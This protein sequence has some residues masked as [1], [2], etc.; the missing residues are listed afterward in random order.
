[1]EDKTIYELLRT[2]A[3]TSG[4]IPAL[5]NQEKRISY[6]VLYQ[7]VLSIAVGLQQLGYRD[8][9]VELTPVLNEDFI[10]AYLAL[11]VAGAVVVIH[12]EGLDI[13]DYEVSVFASVDPA[14]IVEIQSSSAEAYKKVP[15]D[16]ACTL[17]FTSGTSGRQKGVLLTQKN[18]VSDAIHGLQAVGGTAVLKPGDGTIP[19]LP[20]FHMFGITA[21][22]VASLYANLTLHLID[23][24]RYLSRE[25]V[26]ARPKI[27]FLVPM[28]IRTMLNN[29]DK[30]VMAG[31]VPTEMVKEALF[32]GTDIFVSGGAALDPAIVV[33]FEKYG[34]EVLNGYGITECSPIVTVC[35]SKDF[36]LGTVGRVHDLYG[37]KIIIHK[38]MVHISGDIV[39]K[40]Y[41]TPEEDSFVEVNGERYFN[42][43]DF[44]SIDEEG[45][46]SIGGRDSNL[47]IMEDGNNIS[48]EEIEQLFEKYEALEDVL[49]YPEEKNGVTILAIVM[50]IE[51]HVRAT[52]S[53]E[54]A[55]ALLNEF[56]DEVNQTLPSYKKIKLVVLREQPFIRTSLKKIKR[57]KENRNE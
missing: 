30:A 47:I 22:I 46:L 14:Q 7:D 24:I 51:D 17:I 20:V 10:K 8:K 18:L 33:G 43:R 35:R 38:G 40:Q 49:I 15:E 56:V 6:E 32:G 23:D 55:L 37:A 16:N 48:P 19:V 29:A 57:V 12:E 2:A 31:K 45:N 1:M 25:I 13:A 42:T 26:H 4:H 34:I 44:G 39:M 27:V 50:R 53:K 54:E 5:I 3:A 52:L 28:I 9:Y 21:S 41:F 11:I 36:R